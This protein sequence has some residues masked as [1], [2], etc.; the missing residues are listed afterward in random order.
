MKT[1]PII[2]ALV[3]TWV[4]ISFAGAQ[5]PLASHTNAA[6]ANF[7][8]GDYNGNPRM[9]LGL[10]YALK[11]F[12]QV[13]YNR[14][15]VKN[16]QRVKNFQDDYFLRIYAP[17]QEGFILSLGV[18][19][20]YQWARADILTDYRV[21]EIIKGVGLQ[22]G[23]HVIM[24]DSEKQRIT[25]SASYT[26]FEPGIEQQSPEVQVVGCAFDRAISVDLSVIF[27]FTP[28]ALVAGPRVA[29]DSDFSSVFVG[30]QTSVLL[31]H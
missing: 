4:F 18:G 13:S 11:G 30:L 20:I 3:F 15:T 16:D 21:E 29:M 22:G 26:H 27:Y 12:L 28:V 7:F 31:L 19:Y 17:P 2:Q 1:L 24:K 25:F 9:G 14:S 23:L 10:S 8:I 6:S 5:E